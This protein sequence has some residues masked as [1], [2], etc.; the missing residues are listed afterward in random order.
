M[1]YEIKFES[2]EIEVPHG[3]ITTN[4]YKIEGKNFVDNLIKK[5]TYL[6]TMKA[7]FQY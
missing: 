5:Y 2:C 7:L 4:K 3:K 1:S 6:S